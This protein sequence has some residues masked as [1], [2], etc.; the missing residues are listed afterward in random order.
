MGPP[1]VVELVEVGGFALGGDGEPRGRSRRRV[2]EVAVMV[3]A[4]RCSDGVV[5]SEIGEAAGL[6]PEPV[7]TAKTCS[8]FQHPNISATQTTNPD[9]FFLQVSIGKLKYAEISHNLI[10][11]G[12][13]NG[14]CRR[15]RRLTCDRF[16][17]R[18]K[19]HEDIDVGQVEEDDWWMQGVFFWAGPV[20]ITL[21]AWLDMAISKNDN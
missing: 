1:P 9:R 3:E 15:R 20:T 7:A 6:Q 5:E 12:P 2:V 16:C 10:E 8:D 14:A 21:W 13:E 19:S 18:T 11:I 4:L 17:V